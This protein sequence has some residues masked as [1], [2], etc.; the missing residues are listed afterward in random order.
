MLSQKANLLKWKNRMCNDI[1]MQG[2]SAGFAPFF[3][4]QNQNETNNLKTEEPFIIMNLE[5]V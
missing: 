2:R 1:A 3:V 4:V 5:A